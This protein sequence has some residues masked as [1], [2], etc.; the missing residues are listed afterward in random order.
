[1]GSIPSLSQG[2]K[3][4]ELLRLQRVAPAV[5]PIRPLAWEHPCAT[6]A[7]VKRKK[8]FR[9][10]SLSFLLAKC[11]SISH[12]FFIENAHLTFLV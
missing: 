7:A 5:A 11:V 8:G 12:T 1:M 10:N 9:A 2:V 4:P 6:G 3:D